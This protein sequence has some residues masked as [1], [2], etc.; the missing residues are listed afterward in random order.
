MNGVVHRVADRVIDFLLKPK[1]RYKYLPRVDE[2]LS[3]N[4]KERML[5]TCFE[6]AAMANVHG[7]Y[8]EFGLWKGGSLIAAYHISQRFEGLSQMRFYGF[9]SFEGIPILNKN[10]SEAEVFPPGMFQSGGVEQVKRNLSEA[11]VDL[12]RI[13]LI[14]GWYAGTLNRTTRE[15]LSLRHAAVVNVDCD[16]YESTIPVLDF[17]EPH[18]VDGSIIIFDDW[19]CFRNRSEQG[20]QKA[21]SEW[22]DLNR[23][24]RAT[25]Y[26][27]FGWDGKAFII[28]R[29]PSPQHPNSGF[30]SSDGADKAPSATA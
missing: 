13:E 9:D 21:F 10:K 3:F 24:I 16:V 12:T 4:R 7:D 30:S 2:A 19:Y 29:S 26:K 27:E 5:W 20:Q 14:A 1:I 18:L 23:G 8:L 28:N 15:K 17:I 25:P 6:Y 22:L 11:K